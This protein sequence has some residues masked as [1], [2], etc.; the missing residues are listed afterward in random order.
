M[1]NKRKHLRHGFATGAFY[2]CILF[3]ERDMIIID[4][5]G[6]KTLI[7]CNGHGVVDGEKAVICQMPIGVAHETDIVVARKAGFTLADSGERLPIRRSYPQDQ[8]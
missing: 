6:P 1:E 7:A 8:K 2:V 3:F 5:V 4:T